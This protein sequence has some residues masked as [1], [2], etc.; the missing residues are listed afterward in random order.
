MK[1]R[2]KKWTKSQ[3]NFIIKNFKKKGY[4]EIAKKLGRSARSIE[5]QAYKLGLKKM[6]RIH[7][8]IETLINKKPIF[9]TDIIKKFH[10]QKPQ[11]TL[12]II[13]FKNNNIKMAKLGGFDRIY[14]LD[15]EEQRT[16]AYKMVLKK[17]PYYFDGTYKWQRAKPIL[18]NLTRYAKGGRKRYIQMVEVED[19]KRKN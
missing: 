1:R 13:R 16:L 9:F 7:I 5:Q 8:G 18:G 10:S 6:P 4:K 3:I 15:T 12:R 19:G 11:L 2:Y 17:Y 14:F